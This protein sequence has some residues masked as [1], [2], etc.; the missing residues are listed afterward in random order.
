MGRCVPL[1]APLWLY[2]LTLLQLANFP[3]THDKIELIGGTFKLNIVHSVDEHA[4]LVPVLR[5]SVY[6]LLSLLLEQYFLSNSSIELHYPEPSPTPI[7]LPL[8]PPILHR[9]SSS[10]VQMEA[11]QRKRDL[12]RQGLWSLL[13]RRLPRSVTVNSPEPRDAS[14]DLSHREQDTP[15]RASLDTSPGPTQPRQRRFSI[16]GESRTPPPPPEP[17]QTLHDK[18]YQTALQRVEEGRALLSTSPGLVI[19]PPQHLVRLAELEKANPTRRLTGDERTGLTSILGWE[20]KKAAVRG[21]MTGTIGF[22]RQQQLSLLYSEYVYDPDRASQSSAD[23]SPIKFVDAELKPHTHSGARV[24]WVT[25]MYY[26]D[27]DQSLGD[28]I[29]STC[30]RAAEP[31]PQPACKALQGHERRWTHGGICV[32]ARTE[33]QVPFASP[34]VRS[35]EIEMWQ[36]CK[37]CQ[38]STARC[39]M[40]DGT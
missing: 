39:S 15:A 23:G 7:S 27:G 12:F 13:H 21:S 24:R 20:G 16:F 32:T 40:S 6:V 29:T 37:I 26:G 33:P 17:S 2:Q 19:P 4:S 22:L 5:V 35:Q 18:P 14:L 25:Y 31:C 9:N 11:R 1:A 36:S 38:E 28:M 34:D 8:P 30:S 10:E 3:E